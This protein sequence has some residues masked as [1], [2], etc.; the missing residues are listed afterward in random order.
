MRDRLRSIAG[1]IAISVASLL[2]GGCDRA[3]LP[4]GADFGP[5]PTLPDAHPTLVPTVEIARARGWPN[6]LTPTPAADLRV[7]AFAGGL[8]HPRWLYPLPNGDVLVAETDAPDRPA[9]AAGIRGHVTLHVMRRSGSAW[10]SPDRITLL[11]DADGDGRAETRTTFLSHLH[12][13]FGMTLIGNDLYVADT[14]AVLRFPYAD[15]ETEIGEPGVKLL[16]LPAGPLNY[17]W[18][19]NILASPDGTHLY[20]TVGSNSNVGEHG[21]EK[22]QE[23]A[24]IWE[25]ETRTGRYRV[26]ASGLRNPTGLAWEPRNG[27][28]WTTVNERDEIGS[29]LVPDY[30][31]SLTDG[32]FYGWPYSYFGQHID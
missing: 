14:D 3:H 15:G 31:T 6:G 27:Q 28:L 4:P 25:I 8:E 20:V 18:T 17:H 21:I 13:P 29:D 11:R 5:T 26:F 12:S 22:E 19:K 7:V 2:L 9:L 30:L 10:P 24:A 23:R 16:D 32:G 1:L